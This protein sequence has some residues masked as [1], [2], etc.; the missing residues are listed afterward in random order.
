MPT[1]RPHSKDL[2]LLELKK[3]LQSPIHEFRLISLIIEALQFAKADGKKRKE[4]YDFYLKN[5]KFINN[6]DLVDA[7]A[8]HI[9]GRYLLDKPTDILQK[10]AKSQSIWERRISI[11]STFSF[12]KKG[13]YKETFKVAQT[14]LLDKED[15][16]QKAVGWML[17]E[18]GKRCG[19]EFL[20]EFL[21]NRYKTMPRT[22]LRYSIEHFPQEERQNYLKGLV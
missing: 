9:V 20:V 18:V 3:L 13:Q 19:R 22:M 1:P 17:R 15:L 7:S 14:L 12:I 21:K 16:I 10:L 6:W 11:I 5:I 8:E 2:P 4:L